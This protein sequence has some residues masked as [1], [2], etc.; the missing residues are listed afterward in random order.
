MAVVHV[1]TAFSESA[2]FDLNVRPS[3]REISMDDSYV[4]EFNVTS[5]SHFFDPSE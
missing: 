2:T 3:A 5:V 4:L 1:N